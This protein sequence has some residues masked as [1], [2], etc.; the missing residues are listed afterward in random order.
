[1]VVEEACWVKTQEPFKNH[2]VVEWISAGVPLAYTYIIDHK[3]TR[4]K[5]AP[6]LPESRRCVIRG[7]FALGQE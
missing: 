5:L 1:V 6:N 7:A 2:C 3:P 4:F